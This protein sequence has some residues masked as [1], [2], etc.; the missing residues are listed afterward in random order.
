MKMQKNKEHRTQNRNKKEICGRAKGKDLPELAGET[1][2]SCEEEKARKSLE[3]RSRRVM[4][5]MARS[6]N[7]RPLIPNP[8]TKL[9]GHGAAAAEDE[10]EDEVVDG[11]EDDGDGDGEDRALPPPP[12]D[13]EDQTNGFP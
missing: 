11:G 2:S 3:R 12:M 6:R 5:A 4:E 13:A 8:K 10:D 9:R 1:T 7:K